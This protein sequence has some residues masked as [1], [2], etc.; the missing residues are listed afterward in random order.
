M[1]GVAAKLVEELEGGLMDDEPAPYGLGIV[2]ERVALRE[3]CRQE[4]GI[5]AEHD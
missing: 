3:A 5:Y 4:D 2:K 1:D